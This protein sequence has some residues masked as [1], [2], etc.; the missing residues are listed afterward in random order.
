[1]VGVSWEDLSHLA[2][3]QGGVDLGDL[4]TKLLIVTLGEAT[5]HHEAAQ[6]AAFLLASQLEDRVHR[7]LDEIRSRKA[8]AVQC[9]RDMSQEKCL[10]VFSKVL[11][12]EILLSWAGSRPNVVYIDKMPYQAKEIK[13]LKDASPSGVRTTHV[14][15]E[16]F[17]GKILDE[18][19]NPGQSN[20]FSTRVFD[21]GKR[22]IKGGPASGE[23]KRFKS[24][25]LEH[26]S[27]R[28][29]NLIKNYH[30]KFQN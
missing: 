13:K 16:I 25:N 30:Q 7:L 22:E 21:V 24:L 8:E 23:E 20:A 26:L 6:P 14:V 1:M 2:R 9:L 28:V 18:D 15:K 11:G 3:S 12:R 29:I 4:P 27:K 17:E 19:W 5:S 10:V